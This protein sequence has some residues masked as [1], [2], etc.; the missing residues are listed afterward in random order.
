M[1]IPRNKPFRIL[2]IVMIALVATG[3]VI[4]RVYYKGLN[5]AVDPRIIQ[6]R[7]LYER[8]NAYAEKDQYDSVFILMDTIEGIYNSL[9]HYRES[10]ETGVLYNNRAA[11]Y[12]SIYLQPNSADF[13]DDTAVLIADAEK[14]ALKSIS[15]Y[16]NWYEIF[17]KKT[18]EEIRTLIM[19]DFFSEMEPYTP[20]GKEKYLAKRVEEIYEAQNETL[21]RLSVAYTNLGM[22]KRY[23]NK[24]DSAVIFYKKAMDLWERNLTAENNLNIL[25][26]RPLKKRNVLQKLFP[27]EK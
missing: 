11:A 5:D 6:A 4:A 2:F 1:I 20:E 3:L 8:Y 10:Y 23:Q 19:N 16:Q 12:L 21:R 26:N 7:E 17:E 22:V 25:L 27:P 24:Y 14:S 9:S 18:R 13:V 15:I